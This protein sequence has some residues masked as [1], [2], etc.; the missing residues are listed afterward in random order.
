V[1]V[2]VGAALVG[3]TPDSTDKQAWVQFYE[4]RGN[5]VSQIVGGY[6]GILSAFAF[7]WFGHALVTRLGA[8]RDGGDLLTSVARSAATLFTA[9]LILSMLVEIA[10]SAALEIGDVDTPDTADFGIQFEQLAFGILLVAGCLSASVFIGTTTELA[11]QEKMLP[12]WLIWAGF[13]A[14]V[15][16]L[17]G[18]LFFPVVLIPLWVLVVAVVMLV[19]PA[20]QVA[21]VAVSLS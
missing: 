19:R 6:L 2:A 8:R 11:R 9:M 10:V 20:T 5:R 7:L 18:L 12:T 14:A 17:F 1:L 15:A 16:L 21:D 4:D 3:D 13:G